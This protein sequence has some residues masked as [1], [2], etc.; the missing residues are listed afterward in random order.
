MH[1]VLGSRIICLVAFRLRTLVSIL[2]SGISPIPH[3]CLVSS[4]SSAAC[5][6]SLILNVFKVSLSRVPLSPLPPIGYI[7]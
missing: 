5:L 6:L 7:F 1:L 4:P 3:C 2:H